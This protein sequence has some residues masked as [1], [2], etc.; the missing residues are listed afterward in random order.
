MPRSLYKR[1]PSEEL[2]LKA[3]QSL[4]LQDLQDTKWVDETA[5]N[6]ILMLEV[7]DELRSLMFPCM[8]KQF[9]DRPEPT[10]KSYFTVVRQ[11]IKHKGR[12]FKRREKCIQIEKNV[13]RYLT[14]YQLLAAVPEQGQDVS[15]AFT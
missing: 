8:V 5:L 3:V 4:G 6:P 9:L 13:Y 1:E 12:N 11:L 7:L 15:V 14:M 10:Y 2:V